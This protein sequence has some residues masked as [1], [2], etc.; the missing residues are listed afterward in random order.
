M[1][2]VGMDGLGRGAP[3]VDGAIDNAT[4]SELLCEGYLDKLKG[5]SMKN[6]TRHFRLTDSRFSYYEY[7]G[8]PCI[9]SY[10]RQDIC[11]IED[12]GT[13]RFA[14]K[15]LH[16]DDAKPSEQNNGCDARGKTKDM[17]LS[18]QTGAAKNKWLQA[19]RGNNKDRPG[20]CEILVVEGWL[21]HT[22]TKATRWVRVTDRS[23]TIQKTETGEIN[24]SLLLG[25]VIFVD[26]TKDAKEFKI[27]LEEEVGR[28]LKGGSLTFRAK[29]ANERNK[30]CALLQRVFTAAKM[31]THLQLCC[32]MEG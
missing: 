22:N 11:S 26:V 29:S 27:T 8:G 16:G 28:R 18:T 21:N 20:G 24:L 10:P 2:G 4:R 32:F 12:V 31:A 14:L 13:T 3:L 1:T 5:N 25:D 19:L 17:L 6:R 23:I 30:W 15:I 9:N 7:H